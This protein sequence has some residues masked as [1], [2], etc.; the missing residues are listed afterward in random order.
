MQILLQFYFV[1]TFELLVFFFSLSP[2]LT[3]FQL[4]EFSIF[5]SSL[6]GLGVM[7]YI[8]ILPALLP[9]LKNIYLF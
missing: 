6:C 4:N 9:Q 3:F 8:S 5:F 1:L 7:R 2:F